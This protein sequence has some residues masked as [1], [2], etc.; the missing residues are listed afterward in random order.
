MTE[1]NNKLINNEDLTRKL[2]YILKELGITKKKFLEECQKYNPSMSKPTIINMFKGKNTT[3]PTLQTLMTV[4]KVCQNS[5]NENLKRVSFNYLLNDGIYDIEAKNTQI[6]DELGLN[7]DSVE[8]LKR[9]NTSFIPLNKIDVVNYYLYHIPSK[10]WDYLNL[11]KKTY[12]LK[13]SINKNSIK[14]IK[15]VFCDDNLN[16]FLR[17]Y[18]N[19]IHIIIENILQNNIVSLG[20]INELLDIVIVYLK[21]KLIEIDNKMFKNMEDCI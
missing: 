3:T 8:V 5:N 16:S 7:D 17:Q 12:K 10:Y 6:F 9:L 18:F 2:N 14:E 15:E 11:L 20:N 21:A 4:I 13:N 19:N 1:N